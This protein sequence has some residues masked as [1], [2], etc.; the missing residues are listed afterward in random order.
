VVE[1]LMLVRQQQ[2]PLQTER[3]HRHHCWDRRFQ[4]FHRLLDL[5]DLLDLL[6]RGGAEAEQQSSPF[7]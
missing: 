5:L 2:L 4:S 1:E 7:S 6:E 3:S